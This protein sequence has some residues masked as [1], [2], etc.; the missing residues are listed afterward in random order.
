MGTSRT[1]RGAFPRFAVAMG[2]VLASSA[3]SLLAP[4]DQALEGGNH[5]SSLQDGGS[6]DGHEAGA[7]EA[8]SETG[9]SCA[10]SCGLGA[11]CGSDADC[12]SRNCTSGT[13]Q[14]G[15][16]PPPSGAQPRTP[17]LR[18]RQSAD[19]R[20]PGAGDVPLVTSPSPRPAARSQDLPAS[21]RETSTSDEVRFP[22]PSVEG[23]SR[24]TAS[25]ERGRLGVAVALIAV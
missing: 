6:S 5:P 13:C 24:R 25:G 23:G 2:A 16:P 12:A 22:H 8:A 10:P 15:S 14:S 20:R 11:A 18:R 7:S 17:G 3:C 4:S 1:D 9:A 21:G 19:S